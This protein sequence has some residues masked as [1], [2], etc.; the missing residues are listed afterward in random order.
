MKLFERKMMMQHRYSWFFWEV[1][2]QSHTACRVTQQ[3]GI[4]GWGRG[5]GISSKYQLYHII[6]TSIVDSRYCR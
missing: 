1:A 4:Y 2:H 5:S 3:T 6:R